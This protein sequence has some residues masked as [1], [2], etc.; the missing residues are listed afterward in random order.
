MAGHK[1]CKNIHLQAHV[2]RSLQEWARTLN[3]VGH[4]VTSL[5]PWATALLA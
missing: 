4:D 5:T 3:V 1:F 2:G